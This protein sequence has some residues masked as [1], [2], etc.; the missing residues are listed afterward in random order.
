MD[1]GMFSLSVQLSGQK[2]GA[3]SYHTKFISTQLGEQENL[4][5]ENDYKK[6]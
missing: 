2:C 6:G 5:V 3:H 1:F 4:T